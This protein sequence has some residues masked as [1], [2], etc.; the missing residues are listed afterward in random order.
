MSYKINYT[1]YKI[2]NL[3]TNQYYIGVDSYFP[4]RLRQHQSMLKN[5]KH[6]NKYLQYSYNKYG[7]ENFKFEL[8]L[9]CSSREE[10]LN[11]EIFFIKKYKSLERGFNHTIGGEG[12]C[13]YR[14]TKESLEKM[15]SWKRVVTPE[16]R[17]AIS[18]ATRGKSKRKGIKRKNHPDYN[19]WLG[20]E[21]H[22]VAKFSWNDINGMRKLY[23]CGKSLEELASEYN[24]TKT[25]ICNIVNNLFWKDT[26]Y[27][28][29]VITKHV[30]CIEDN[31]EFNNIK[32]VQ[33]YYKI[34]YHP[35][36]NS[37]NN[38]SKKV[39]TKYG[40]KSFK[41]VSVEEALSRFSQTK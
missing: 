21:K 28:K 32:N 20:G 13:E 23:C 8:L 19:K 11:K 7:A 35:I 30:I 39:K 34:S 5:N 25:Y 14:H 22:P 1:V 24:V 27:K 33:N 41:K 26:S 15:A 31:L 3:K 16:W 38:N 12:T 9:K 6:K 18:N 37:I 17:E 2:T 10:M 29:D 36:Y 4:K 40:K